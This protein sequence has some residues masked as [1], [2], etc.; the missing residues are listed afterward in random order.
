MPARASVM[1]LVLEPLFPGMMKENID[2]YLWLY[3]RDY[4]YVTGLR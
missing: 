2:C 3:P 1:K 4:F